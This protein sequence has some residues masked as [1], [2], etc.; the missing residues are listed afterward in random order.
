MGKKKNR[1]KS[2]QR[3]K[4]E[5]TTSLKETRENQLK[6]SVHDNDFASTKSLILGIH[7]SE[8]KAFHYYYLGNACRE[9]GELDE[10]MTHLRTGEQLLDS[11]ADSLSGWIYFEIGF[12]YG[13]YGFSEYNRE[14]EEHWFKKAVSTGDTAMMAYH[15]LYHVL[16][17][18]DLD[19]LIEKNLNQY[20]QDYFSHSYKIN[21]SKD[22]EEL[23]NAWDKV[24]S[25]NAKSANLLANYGKKLVSFKEVES[26]RDSFMEILPLLPS[27]MS[28]GYALFMIGST[29]FE[30]KENAKANDYFNQALPH[31][32][33]AKELHNAALL[34]LI[35]TCEESKAINQLCQKLELEFDSDGFTFCGYGIFDIGYMEL[36]FDQN[37]TDFSFPLIVKAAINRLKECG[38]LSLE[39]RSWQH[40]LEGAYESSQSDFLEQLSLTLE[41]QAGPLK[42]VKNSLISSA[43]DNIENVQMEDENT[44]FIEEEFVNCAR[45]LTDYLSE[46]KPSDATAEGIAGMLLSSLFAI[47]KYEDVVSVAL[48]VSN[49][50]DKDSKF[51]VAYSFNET[52]DAELAQANYESYLECNPNSSAALNNLANIYKKNGRIEESIEL[53]KKAIEIDGDDEHAPAN[54]KKALEQLKQDRKEKNTEEKKLKAALASW[55]SLDFNKKKI[56]TTLNIIDEFDSFDQLADYTGM[57]S[58]WAEKHYKRLVDLRM[59]IESNDGYTINPEI[60][61]L[62]ERENSHSVAIQVVRNNDNVLYKPVFNSQLEYTIYRLMIGLFPNHLVFPNV[63]LQSIFDYGKIK[64]ALDTDHFKYYLMASVDLCVISTANYLP[65]LGYEIDSPYHDLEKQIERDEKKNTIFQSGGVPLVRLRPHGRPS[66]QEIRHVIL[67]NTRELGRQLDP[68]HRGQVDDLLRSINED[69]PDDSH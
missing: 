22:L 11:D 42:E 2:N 56:L 32:T 29:F 38:A 54:L 61:P 4:K 28:Y 21:H 35:A 33:S 20:P 18:E 34:G 5:V 6:K 43:L 36:Y 15:R 58:Y 16:P 7:P 19:D 47:R 10:A 1:R 51:E 31:S 24:K 66:E 41:I 37:P 14:L 27:G 57:N 46:L 59:V 25:C 55:P 68:V 12:L 9:L 65:I 45:K 50:L 64:D 13:R 23:D 44:P 52:G 49:L 17:T 26:A 60:L 63:S 39:S 53:Y 3:S 62:I 48:A 30:E 40:F 69:K 8:R 67:E